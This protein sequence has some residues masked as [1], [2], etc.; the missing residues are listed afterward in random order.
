MMATATVPT[1]RLLVEAIDPANRANPYPIYARLRETPVSRQDDGTYVVSTYDEIRLLLHDPRI[2]SHRLSSDPSEV[3]L[4]CFPDTPTVIITDPPEHS[5]LRGLVTHYF[6]PPRIN[7]M[8]PD[9][10]QVVKDL[11]DAKKGVRELDLVEDFAYPLP[12][13]IISHLLGV[14]LEDQDRFRVWSSDVV[15]GADPFLSEADLQE[16]VRSR[17]EMCDYMNQLSETLRVHPGDDLFSAF[18]AGDP[19]FRMSERDLLNTMRLLLVAGHE[20]TVNLIA[21]SMLALLRNPDVVDRVRA[22]PALVI[23]MIEEVL[24]YDPMVQLRKRT[25]LAEIQIAGVTIPEGASVMLVLG[26]GNRDPA[27]FVDP[28]RFWPERPDNEHFGF[29]NGEHYCIGAPLARL[30]GVAAVQAL[31]RRLEGP[32]L[33]VDPPPYRPA[34]TLR[35]PAHLQI[36]VDRIRD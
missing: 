9:I 23:P 36:T 2:S 32:R 5:R 22:D 17:V 29:G 3:A 1:G 13:T 6:T 7:G 35:G 14:P 11:L 24:R 18:V 34:A 31:V 19:D 26:S 33:V 4:D 28:D 20:T 25:T 10:D 27:R 16:V 15:R 8:S 30:E 12:V 21:N